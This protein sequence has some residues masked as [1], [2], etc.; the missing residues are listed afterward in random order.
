MEPL[1]PNKSERNPVH[2]ECHSGYKADEYPKSFRWQN[3]RH[4]IVEIIDRWHQGERSPEF[5]VSDYFKVT[6][7]RSET[8]ILKHDLEDDAWYLVYLNFR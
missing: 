2:V 7:T 4:E 8:Y 6:T 5:H 3:E 1:T